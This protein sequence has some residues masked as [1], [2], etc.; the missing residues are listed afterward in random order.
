MRRD[1]GMLGEASFFNI[2]L[3]ITEFFD[4]TS[5]VFLV[6]LLDILAKLSYGSFN[7]NSIRR[8][9]DNSILFSR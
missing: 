2:L 9:L 4:F 6:S 8:S 5:R 1:G 7:P 3:N